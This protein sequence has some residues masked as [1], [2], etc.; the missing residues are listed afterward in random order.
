DPGSVGLGRDDVESI[1]S[2]VVDFYKTGF[3]PALGLCIRRRGEVI[4][5]RTIGH[6]RG[7]SPDDPEGTPLVRAT[8]KTLFNFFSG[9]KAVTAMLIHLLAERD[10]LHVDEP[11]ATFIPEFHNESWRCSTSSSRLTGPG[12]FPHITRSRAVSFSRSSSNAFRELVFASFYAGKSRSRS[13][14][15]TSTTACPKS[16]STKLQSMRARVPS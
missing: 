5:D 12:R 16:G 15:A 11:V 14:R 7:N 3:H 1:W 6:A 2:A 4:L 13:A 8:P 9:S 10:Q